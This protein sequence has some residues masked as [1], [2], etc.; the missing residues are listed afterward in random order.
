MRRVLHLVGRGLRPRVAV[1]VIFGRELLLRRD[2][3]I[4]PYQRVLV[5]GVG[6]ISAVGAEVEGREAVADVIVQVGVFI[7]RRKVARRIVSHEWPT[8]RPMDSAA[9]FYR[10]LVQIHHGLLSIKLL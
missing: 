9:S 7:Q 2:G 8:C 6:G 4:A 1:E 10:I 3:V 5:E